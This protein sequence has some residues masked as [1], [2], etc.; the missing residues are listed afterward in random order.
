MTAHNNRVAAKMQISSEMI[1][2]NQKDQIHNHLNAQLMHR[3]ADELHRTKSD[4]IK[5][6]MLDSFP[7]NSQYEAEVELYV[8]TKQ[9]LVDLLN[10][11]KMEASVDIREQITSVDN[12]KNKL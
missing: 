2:S 12:W 9:E 3:I 6:K 7:L 5:M 4:A 10:R 11:T 8:F 1:D